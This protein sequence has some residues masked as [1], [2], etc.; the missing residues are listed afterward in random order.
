[1]HGRKTEKKINK[2]RTAYNWK[3]K[4]VNDFEFHIREARALCAFLFGFKNRDFGI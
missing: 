3:H 4:K 2:S 1:M